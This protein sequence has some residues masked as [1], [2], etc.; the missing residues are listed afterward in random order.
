M[1]KDKLEKLQREEKEKELE[2]R[3][4]IRDIKVKMSSTRREQAS[5][6]AQPPLKKRKIG[7]ENFKRVEQDGRQAVKRQ[8]IEEKGMMK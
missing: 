2:L 1:T 3:K 8:V 6:K 4:K 5:S 7:Q